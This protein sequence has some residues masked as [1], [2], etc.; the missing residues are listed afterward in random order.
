MGFSVGGEY[1]GVV[2]YLLEGARPREARADRLL[3]LGGERGRRP[4]R[5]RRFGA[6]RRR[7]MSEASLDDWG[8]RIPFFVGAALAGSVWIARSTM[9]ESPEFERQRE[10]GSVPEVPAPPRPRQPPRRHRPLLRD[11]GARLDHLLCRHHLRSGVPDLGRVAA[12]A[13]RLV[14]VDDRRGGGDR[15]H[16][17]RRRLV[18][19]RRPH[20]ACWS[21]WRSPARRCR[22]RC[23]R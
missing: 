13:R 12:G 18:R 5:G 1:T 20:A 6:D 22:S 7:S 15:G 11:L 14:A 16:A 17:V 8:W 21:S 9:H 2:A 23:S 4:A 19:P 3:G 10:A